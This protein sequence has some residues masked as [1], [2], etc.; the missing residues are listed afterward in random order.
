MGPQLGNNT[1]G[2]QSTQNSEWE[3]SCR[4]GKHEVDDDIMQ[5]QDLL[6]GLV[7]GDSE[8]GGV[9]GDD[10]DTVPECLR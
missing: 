9:A 1:L 8:E 2:N 6:G 5:E 7:D 10:R 3:T 4:K